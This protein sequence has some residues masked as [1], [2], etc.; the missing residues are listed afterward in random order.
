MHS[1]YKL[2]FNELGAK[3]LAKL[4]DIE[5]LNSFFAD[6]LRLYLMIN[7]ASNASSMGKKA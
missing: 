4:G 3:I 7:M 5:G 1:G 2:V 6:E